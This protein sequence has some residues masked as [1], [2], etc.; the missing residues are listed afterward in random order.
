MDAGKPA[1]VQVMQMKVAVTG[2]TGLIGS[3][4][5]RML[6]A[7]GK[8]TLLCLSRQDTQDPD[9]RQTDYSQ[10]SLNALFAGVDAVIHLAAIRGGN[11]PA[12]YQAYQEN[13][14]LTEKILKAMEA[15]GVRKIVF[16]SS[17]SVYSD[18]AL[19]PWSESQAPAPV[20]FYGLSKLCCEHLCQLYRRSGIVPVIFRCAHVLG[21]ERR[22]YMLE[23]FMNLASEHQTLTVKGKSEAEREFIYVKDVAAALCWALDSESAEGVYN[24]GSGEKLT[25]LAVAQNVNAAFENEGNIS[26]L[27]QQSEG[28]KPSYMCG[29][30]LSAAGFRT[31]YS[32]YE[33]VCDIRKEIFSGQTA[34]KEV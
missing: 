26:Y 10:E 9:F 32:F 12:G 6:K 17:I 24:L 3:C 22:G 21:Y 29:E 4:L 5:V 2:A 16:L 30:R 23:I 19:L 25:N 34:G 33:G 28:I 27:D 14:V 11:S 13:E 31:G 1:S 8:H 18:T 7:E 20:N 15:N